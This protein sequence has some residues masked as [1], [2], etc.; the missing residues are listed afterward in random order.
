[1]QGLKITLSVFLLVVCIVASNAQLAKK[2]AGKFKEKFQYSTAI[3]LYE[4][5]LNKHLED[6]EA[7]LDLA[8]CYT[9]INDAEKAIKWYSLS[10][11]SAGEV[12]VHYLNYAKMLSETEKYAESKKWFKKY[13]ETSGPD[14]RCQRQID[15]IGH[16]NDFYKDSARFRIETLPCNSG[17]VDYAP[18]YFDNGLLFSSARERHK[19][20]LINRRVAWNMK[21]YLDLY[22]Y[23]FQD[24]S[25]S[26][27]GKPINSRLHE[28]ATTFNEAQTKIFFTRN[29]LTK[30]KRGKSE[31]GITKIELYS[32]IKGVKGWESVTSFPFDNSEYSVGDPYY[33]EPENIMFFSSDMPGGFG[34]LDIYRS[35]WVDGAWTTP[36]NLGGTINSEGNERSAFYMGEGYFV[37]A[38]D[39]QEGLGGLDNYYTTI[40][41]ST[42][43]GEVIKNWGYPINTSKDDFGLIL[44]KEKKLGYFASNRDGGVGQDDIYHVKIVGKP[45]VRVKGAVYFKKQSEPISERKPL[46]QAVVEVT[47]Q[48]GNE[49]LGDVVSGDKGQFSVDV[50]PGFDYTFKAKKDSLQSEP[51]TITVS[52]GKGK[53]K[54][55]ELLVE[56]IPLNPTKV[57]FSG[58]VVDFKSQQPLSGAAIYL[59]NEDNN[60][61]KYL[62]SDSKG[63]FSAFLD[64]KSHYVIKGSKTDYL[65]NCGRFNSPEASKE[66]WGLAKPFTLEKISVERIFKIDKVYY[67]LAKWN[68]RTDA[69]KELDK[70]VVFLKE[71]PTITVELGSH[72]DSRG[73]DDYNLD[74]STKRA[75]SAREYIVLQGIKESRITG[76]GYGE[77]RLTNQCANGV[78]CSEEEHQANRRTELR[79]TGVIQATTT[80]TSVDP[81]ALNPEA[82]HS[83]CKVL[84]VK[85]GG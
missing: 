82:D 3:D 24:S 36:V 6:K 10:I 13:L 23:S 17:E 47:K 15:A 7:M 59:F 11:E 66:N 53:P 9:K 38:S 58:V 31:D 22:H 52:E 35:S 27:F 16:I 2:R 81:G 26:N 45:D 67:D 44:G 57:L 29:D 33:Y 42:T 75:I 62:K 25:L 48:P 78:K 18:T 12:G 55:V 56:S 50:I 60:Q 51:V 28:G 80:N 19:F 54:D 73:T 85:K 64:P 79:I 65:T 8:E 72:T 46:Y 32:A 34:G 43:G 37:F 30:H 76:K 20:N 14:Q 74:L 21:S 71:N 1:M 84:G 69:A 77:S 39:G 83:A 68:I 5:H 70:V 41:V 49:R 63:A 40:D 61:I 4:M